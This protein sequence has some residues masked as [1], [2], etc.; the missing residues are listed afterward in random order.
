MDKF[1]IARD[2][3]IKGQIL[4]NNIKELSVVESM[5]NVPR[6]LFVP[7]KYKSLSYADTNISLNESRFLISPM[8]FAKMLQAA[9]VSKDSVVLD[10]ACGSGYSSAVLSMIAKKVVAIESNAD[11]ASKANLIL[12]SLNLTNVIILNDQMSLGSPESAPYDVIFINGSI[13]K[14]PEILLSQLAEGGRLVTAF[15]NKKF[16]GSIVLYTKEQNQIKRND[17]FYVEV[18]PIDDF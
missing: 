3:M 10:I 17:I 1:V 11:L 12:R 14:T 18:P 8:I 4:P 7:E 2:N 16:G 15:N 5:S 9:V 6:N 13:S